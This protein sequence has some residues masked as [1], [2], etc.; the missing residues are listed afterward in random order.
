MKNKNIKIRVREN[1]QRADAKK[2]SN[3]ILFCLF[4]VVVNKK[5][6]HRSIKIKKNCNTARAR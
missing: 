4:V 1:K 3:L 6:H 2:N 5:V